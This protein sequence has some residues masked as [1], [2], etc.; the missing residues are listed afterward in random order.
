MYKWVPGPFSGGGVVYLSA[1]KCHIVSAIELSI[2][3][4]KSNMSSNVF[5]FFTSLY[6]RTVKSAI[7]LSINMKCLH[8]EH[9][10]VQKVLN[11]ELSIGYI[12]IDYF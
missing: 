2:F 1:T 4:L 11:I 6:K 8:E 3:D 7:Q 12:L 10:S 5:V 9:I